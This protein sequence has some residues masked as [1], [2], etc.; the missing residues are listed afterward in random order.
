MLRRSTADRPGLI[1]Q[2]GRQAEVHVLLDAG[3]SLEL[4]GEVLPE[5]AD[6][7]LD[8]Q[9][10]RRCARG[11]AERADAL[12]PAEIES[13]GAF[14]QVAR[15]PGGLA[16]LAQA[17]G[18]RAV[19]RAHHQDQVDL[20]SER[21]HRRLPVLRRVADVPGIGPHDPRE[22]GLER[23]DDVAGV[24]D[25]QRGLGDEGEPLGVARLDAGDVLDRTDQV[26]PALDPPHRTLDLGMS[27]VTDQHDIEA[28]RGVPVTLFVYL[29]DQRTRRVDHAQSALMRRQFH[30]LRD[31]MRAEYGDR[32]LRDLVDL[33]DEPGALA[34]QRL[35]DV[36]VVDDLVADVDRRAE[37]LQRALD[38]LD[39]PLH[40]RAETPRLC[41]HHP[42][43]GLAHA[44][45]PH[46]SRS[47]P[48][49]CR[50]S[51]SSATSAELKGGITI[52]PAGMHAVIAQAS[53]NDSVQFC[54][55]DI[56]A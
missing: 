13:F 18:V 52:S 48:A 34:L 21:A 35:Y 53:T 10:G 14:D 1:G 3:E 19:L 55:L 33:V 39:R 46:Q 6:Q 9:L 22:A 8:Q 11:D 45:F 51:K 23:G 7:I 16:D 38:D 26:D 15:G 28:V 36:L 44:A 17:V 24:V 41:Q 4:Y 47:N 2:L 42:Q 20:A 56:Q 31:A 37:P 25:A 50:S 32:A 5:L 29:G 12:E 43:R 27:G 54:C 30:A 40:A 49:S